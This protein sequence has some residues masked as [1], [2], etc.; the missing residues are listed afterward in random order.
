MLCAFI[1]P[2]PVGLDQRGECPGSRARRS[3][4]EGLPGDFPEEEP[5]LGARVHLAFGHGFLRPALEREVDAIDDALRNQDH[6]VGEQN[7]EHHQ[8]EDL[9]PRASPGLDEKDSNGHHGGE[10]GRHHRPPAR[11]S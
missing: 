6:R 1:G 11:A 5:R 9:A 8:E 2:L 7:R 3:L 10:R 4:L